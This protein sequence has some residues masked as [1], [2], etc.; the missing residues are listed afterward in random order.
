MRTYM[1]I[2]K[3]S[4]ETVATPV[5]TRVFVKD[6]LSRDRGLRSR[7]HSPSPNHNAPLF[8][9]VFASLHNPDHTVLHVWFTSIGIHGVDSVT[10]INCSVNGL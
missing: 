10:V 4:K 9:M 2:H 6:F 1:C 8:V 5:S 3:K 7:D